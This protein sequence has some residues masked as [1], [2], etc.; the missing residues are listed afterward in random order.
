MI[1]GTNEFTIAGTDLGPDSEKDDEYVALLN[2]DGQMAAKAEIVFSSLQ[3]V[4][5]ALEAAL[6]PGSYTLVVYTRS[7]MGEAYGVKSATRKIS[8]A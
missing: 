4:R 3:L 5:C 2:K 8:V 1:A 7:G 6:E